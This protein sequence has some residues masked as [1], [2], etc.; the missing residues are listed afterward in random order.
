MTASR[1]SPEPRRPDRV[2]QIPSEGLSEAN[3]REIRALL[4]AAFGADEDERFTDDDWAHAL[5]G[6]HFVLDVGGEIVAHA[7][8]V[9]REIHVGDRPLRAGYVEAV[10]TVPDRQ[11]RGYGSRVIEAVGAHLR[12]RYE[13]GVLGTGRHR[14]YERLG[15]STWRGHSFVRTPAGPE[16]TP[17]EDGFILVLPTPATPPLDPTAP[18]S[19]DSRPGDAW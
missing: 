15:W 17:E 4:D 5:G 11:G 7:S 10:A 18:I 1:R 3:A 12:E 6:V 16:P 14:F 9:E 19:C 2:R 8:V 13:L